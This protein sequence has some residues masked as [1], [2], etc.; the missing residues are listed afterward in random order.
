MRIIGGIA[1]G[2]KLANFSNSKVRPTSDRVKES[3]FNILPH[4][5]YNMVVLDLFAGTGN[6]GLEALSRGAK[7]AVFID[8]NTASLIKK[9]ITICGFE[10]SCEIIPK[11]VIIGIK[12]LHK[13]KEKFDIIFIDPPYNTTL[14]YNVLEEISKSCLCHSESIIIFE[15]FKKTSLNED[16]NFNIIDHRIYGSSAIFFLKLK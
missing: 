6:L 14:I 7:E 2:R 8:N 9:N 3:I 10:N 13:R 12:I 1:K 11:D 15:D 5:L 4:N 16:K